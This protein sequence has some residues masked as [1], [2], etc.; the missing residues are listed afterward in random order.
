MYEWFHSRDTSCTSYQCYV[1]L[2]SDTESDADID[3][4]LQAAISA[5]LID[6]RYGIVLIY[7]S[8]F[9]TVWH[10]AHAQLLSGLT[11]EV[12]VNSLHFIFWKH[13]C[14]QLS[15]SLQF[16]VKRQTSNI[17]SSVLNIYSNHCYN[18]T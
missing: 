2:L 16:D 8:Q 18:T 10:V 14:L 13:H 3:N 11:C 7:V 1:S 5:S 17:V 15:F 6:S 12:I 9:M 4:D